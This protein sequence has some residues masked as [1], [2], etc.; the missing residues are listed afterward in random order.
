MNL[1]FD[2]VDLMA[3][4]YIVKEIPHEVWPDRMLERQKLSSERGMAVLDDDYGEKTFEMS[5]IITGTSQSNLEQNLK[6]FSEL[7]SRK[8]K[9][10]DIGH[11]GSTLRYIAYAEEV[12]IMRG[13]QHITHAPFKVRFVVPDGVGVDPSSV[14][15]SNDNIT[16]ASYNNTVTILGS[17]RPRPTITIT[18]DSATDVTKAE[19]TFNGDKITVTENMS[20]ADILIIDIENKKVTLNGTEKDYDGIF[21]RFKVGSNS[22]TIAMTSTDHQYDLIISYYRT[23]L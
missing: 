5:G 8:A 10:L 22:Y 7:M 14:N 18:F 11:G 2:S 9:N 19:I 17:A 6:T 1:S 3:S 20:A 21:P 16:D 23:Y 13:S 12:K 15:D 4:P